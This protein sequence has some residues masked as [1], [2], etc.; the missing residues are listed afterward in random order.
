MCLDME[1]T[2][3][4]R[5]FKFGDEVL[6]NQLRANSDDESKI[7]GVKRCVS[8]NREEKWV[9]DIIMGDSTTTLYFAITEINSDVI[10]GYTSISDIDY[11]MGTC[12]WS[13]IKL[14]ET[15]R[16]KGYS[17]QV[18]LLIEKYVFEE[19]RMVRCKGVCLE[20]HAV[21]LKLM[22]R[23]GYTKEGLMRKSIYKNGKHINQWL[24]SIT[25]DDYDQIKNEYKL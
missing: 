23:A 5:A 8:I 14:I 6:I 19:M 9:H 2:I 25:D 4:F 22:E 15:V 7:G 18:A 20:D 10:I 21:A 24:L 17:I 1:F 11:R 12:F 3:K 13:G 16:G